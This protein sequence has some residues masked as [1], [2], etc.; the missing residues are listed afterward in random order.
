MLHKNL[1]IVFSIHIWL[2]DIDVDMDHSYEETRLN[3]STYDTLVE[4]GFNNCEKP[5]E[6]QE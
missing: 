1:K 6:I 5:Q 2:L 3:I 4:D